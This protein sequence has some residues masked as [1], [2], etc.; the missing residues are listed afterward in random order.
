M[1]I[2]RSPS[3]KPFTLDSTKYQANY[4]FSVLLPLSETAQYSHGKLEVRQAIEFPVSGHYKINLQLKHTSH[5]ST[6]TC[7]AP[8]RLHVICL[9]AQARVR[10]IKISTRE[11]SSGIDWRSP[12]FFTFCN[13]NVLF[14]CICKGSWIKYILKILVI[15]PPLSVEAWKPEQ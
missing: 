11:D 4:A 15:N 14:T 2:S 1:L 5:S 10:N 12:S 13:K 9:S 8:G 3:K 7:R 6:S